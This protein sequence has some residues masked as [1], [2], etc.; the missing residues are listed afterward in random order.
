MTL[1]RKKILLAEDDLDDRT[2]FLEYL[3][4]RDDIELMPIAENGIEVFELLNALSIDD[5]PDLIVLDQNMPMKSG[6]QTLEELKSNKIFLAIPVV[7]YST[8]S[9][10]HLVENCINKGAEMVV[11]KPLTPKEYEGMM[12]NFMLTIM[13]QKQ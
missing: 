6:I 12:D 4:E 1:L 9:D 7:I 5:Y 2:F 13:L 8:Y 3:S 10:V 11:T